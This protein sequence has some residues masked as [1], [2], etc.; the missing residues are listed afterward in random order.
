MTQLKS[1]VLAGIGVIG[2]LCAIC[3]TLPIMGLVGL[4]AYEALFCENVWLQIGGAGLA[5]GAIVY[6]LKKGFKRGCSKT[7]CATSC[8]CQVT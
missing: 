5:L 8:G 2:G 1:K 6:F 7:T 3:C 4:G